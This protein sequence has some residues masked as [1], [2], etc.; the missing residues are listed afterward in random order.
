M[1][2]AGAEMRF[3]SKGAA[4]HERLREGFLAIARSEPGRCAVIDAAGSLED[5]EARVWETVEERL[6]QYG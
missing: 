3:E 1:S 4:F 2:G 5:V 6:T